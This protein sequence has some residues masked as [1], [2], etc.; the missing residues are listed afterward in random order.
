L[1]SD[2]QKITELANLFLANRVHINALTTQGKNTAL[3]LAIKYNNKA[4]FT[5]LIAKNAKLKTNSPITPHALA[6]INHYNAANKDA[7]DYVMEALSQASEEEKQQ[8]KTDYL[9]P[10]IRSGVNVIDQSRPFQNEYIALK[11]VTIIKLI[12]EHEENLSKVFR[13]AEEIF[14][15]TDLKLSDEKTLERLERFN[16]KCNLFYAFN[17][18]NNSVLIR[19]LS[20][21][22]RTSHDYDLPSTVNYRDFYTKLLAVFIENGITEQDR[23]I[24][25]RFLERYCNNDLDAIRLGIT[26]NTD[27]DKIK[28]SFFCKYDQI[29]LDL[30]TGILITFLEFNARSKS[31]PELIGQFS[32]PEYDK[33]NYLSFIYKASR[34]N[35][36]LYKKLIETSIDNGFN[37]FTFSEDLEQ[38]RTLLDIQMSLGSIIASRYNN[39]RFALTLDHAD[40]SGD[41]MIQGYKEG[42][43]NKAREYLTKFFSKDSS[44]I[45]NIKELS[46]YFCS[47]NDSQNFLKNIFCF[48]VAM[49]QGGKIIIRDNPNVSKVAHKINDGSMPISIYRDGQMFYHSSYGF[50]NYRGEVDKMLKPNSSGVMKFNFNLDRKELEDISKRYLFPVKINFQYEIYIGSFKDGLFH[51]DGFLKFSDGAYYQG[52]FKKGLFDGN[53]KIVHP[54]GKSYDVIFQKGKLLVDLRQGQRAVEFITENGLR[55]G[56]LPG[57]KLVIQVKGTDNRITSRILENASLAKE[58]FKDSSVVDKRSSAEDD[59]IPKIP[60]ILAR[61][62]A[63]SFN[64]FLDDFINNELNKITEFNQLKLEL[65]KLESGFNIVSETIMIMS[66]AKTPEARLHLT[67]SIEPQKQKLQIYRQRIDH[68][69]EF[70]ETTKADLLKTIQIESSGS[71]LGYDQFQE[72]IGLD[73]LTGKFQF[74]KSTQEIVIDDKNPNLVTPFVQSLESRLI[75]PITTKTVLTKSEQQ[76]IKQ[77]IFELY[78][79]TIDQAKYQK[80]QE[81][82]RKLLSEALLPISPSSSEHF[83]HIDIVESLPSREKIKTTAPEIKTWELRWNSLSAKI[84]RRSNMEAKLNHGELIANEEPNTSPR[85]PKANFSLSELSDLS[86]LL[87]GIDLETTVS[88]SSVSQKTQYLSLDDFRSGCAQIEN[89]SKSIKELQQEFHTSLEK[90]VTDISRSENYNQAEKA[91]LTSHIYNLNAY[92]IGGQNWQEYVLRNY[93]R[94]SVQGRLIGLT[95]GLGHASTANKSELT[96]MIWTIS[97]LQQ[98]HDTYQESSMKSS[99]KV[100]HPLSIQ[101]FQDHLSTI[102]YTKSSQSTANISRGEVSIIKSSD[103]DY[104]QNLVEYFASKQDLKPPLD[105]IKQKLNEFIKENLVAISQDTK[106]SFTQD[107]KTH[108]N[109]LTTESDGNFI[110]KI[111]SSDFDLI[112]PII[113]S[114]RKNGLMDDFQSFCKSKYVD[115]SKQ[116]QDIEIQKSRL[117][118][119]INLTS[120]DH[121]SSYNINP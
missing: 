5:V 79:L 107:F 98:I 110:E 94:L 80:I 20:T 40:F 89:T 62:I 9:V 72:L 87:N 112:Q 1:Q 63:E 43:R 34:E 60:N 12:I 74:L 116:Y 14:Y 68:I 15:T 84:L 36:E 108:V 7:L 71:R 66:S 113:E 90:L 115:I 37:L 25:T 22:L 114:A 81:D 42:A 24:F 91:N 95:T 41:S 58:I 39:G 100:N 85:I 35:I 16:T 69:R 8:I 103:E 10:L 47:Q 29:S 3:I 18:L 6:H 78:S 48:L 23:E 27:V 82:L 46:F 104:L 30:V 38:S 64:N 102:F 28:Y 88:S 97:Q 77:K 57:N 59:K 13:D 61:F 111:K 49:N 106:S 45:E 33:F 119:I 65:E 93:E 118:Q 99:A 2:Q 67:E 73:S 51:G 53:G 92:C 26:D 76:E 56:I 50:I 120:Q 21:N 86:K 70:F 83:D 75:S 109:A 19:S 44:E 52:S 96:Q 17:N 31:L 32:D 101:K 105:L 55:L 117:G 54:D 4:L 121:S 11:A